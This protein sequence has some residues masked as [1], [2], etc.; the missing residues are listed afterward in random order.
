MAKK[1]RSVSKQSPAASD[2]LSAGATGGAIGDLIGRA[3]SRGDYNAFNRGAAASA[4][5][6]NLTGMTIADILAAQALPAGDPN[7][8]FAVGKYQLI[9]PSLRDAVKQL[10]IGPSEIFSPSLQEGIFRNYLL[11]IKRPAVKAYIVAKSDDL[12]AAQ[13]ALAME[14]ATVARPDTDMS[15]YGGA[16]AMISAKDTAQALGQ[17]RD[18]YADLVAGAWNALSHA[19]A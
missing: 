13:M 19:A 15:Y 3:E 8:L 11:G 7:R 5:S 18:R 1:T 6:V 2:G 17:E 4:G 16:P 10:A 14:F 12:G 9:P